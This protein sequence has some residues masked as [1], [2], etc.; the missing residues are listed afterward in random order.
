M[1]GI[2][3][4]LGDGRLN[5]VPICAGTKMEEFGEEAE[6]ELDREDL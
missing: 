6:E 2:E 5:A 3:E 4:K 1:D